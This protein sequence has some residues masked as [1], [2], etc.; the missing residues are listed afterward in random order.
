MCYACGAS[1]GDP[2]LSRLPASNEISGWM[3]SSVPTVVRTDTALYNQIDGAA[4]KYVDRGWVASAYAVYLDGTSSV[5]VAIHDMGSATGAE[6]LFQYELP[7]SSI[8]I[9]GLSSAVVDMGQPNSYTSEAVTGQYCINVSISD[10]SD[11]ALTTV[12]DFTRAILKR[13]S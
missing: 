7:I 12:E 2:L 8:P 3:M 9:D 6:S 11:S 4:P 1:S 13:G 10:R 5:D